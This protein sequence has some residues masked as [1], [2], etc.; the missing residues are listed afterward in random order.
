MNSPHYPALEPV[1]GATATYS[2]E[3]NKLRLYLQHRVSRP[4]FDALRDAGFGWAP[5]QELLVCP[6]WTPEAEDVA[7]T[8]AGSIDDEDMSP[9]E[10]AADR[11][12][13]FAEYRDKRADEAHGHADHYDSGPHAHGFQSQARADRAAARHD[14]HA[15]RAVTQWGRAEYWQR[16]TAGVIAHAL[17]KSR[18][19]VRHRR[20]KGIEA[21]LRRLLADNIPHEVIEGV[22]AVVRYCGQ[23]YADKGH[24]AVGVFGQGRARIPRSF[25]KE[26]G[27]HVL[28]EHAQRWA[29]HYRLRIDYE[30]QMLAADGGTMADATDMKAGGFIGSMR[31][32][33]VTKDRAGRVSKVYMRGRH[34]YR[35]GETCLHAFN[36][37]R[38]PHAYRAPTDEERAEW[39]AIVKA[40]KAG[41]PK[42]APIINPA[43]EDAEALLTV[44]K[45]ANA[46]KLRRLQERG[47][48]SESYCSGLI[49]EAD[50]MGH[51]KATQKVYSMN[52]KGDY[53]Q[54]G[55]V[56]VAAD[57]SE[58]VDDK[59]V[60]F[61]VRVKNWHGSTYCSLN[62]PITLTDKPTKPLPVRVATVAQEATEVATP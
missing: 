27:A 22:A 4:M 7:L 41:T 17:H 10:R 14:R 49:A 3:D 56:S 23:E 61:R 60:A 46:A 54:A 29:D 2:P 40:S 45:A 44:W 59:P 42:A 18:P 32:E 36:A 16:R 26:Y 33:K 12:E 48:W 21:D 43:P 39:A 31:I 9:E 51:V 25:R 58:A 37:E 13:R 47:R 28:S 19:G 62:L 5:K 55:M 8:V 57:W 52:S 34:P 11:A 6:R 30:K 24:D 20:I 38:L 50:A 53:A 1:A 35:S 15:S